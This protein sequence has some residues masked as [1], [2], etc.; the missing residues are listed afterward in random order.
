[1]AA[2]GAY[3]SRRLYTKHGLTR[4]KHA[5]KVLGNRTIDRRTTMG[6]ALA[7]WRSDLLTDLGLILC[8]RKSVSS[9]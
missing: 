9:S 2:E 4:M 5:V 8:S 1:M 3:K 7:A 6:R